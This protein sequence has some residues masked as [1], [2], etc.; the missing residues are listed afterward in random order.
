MPEG[1]GISQ[2]S[3]T[4]FAF[5]LGFTGFPE[6]RAHLR[7]ALRDGH[8]APVDPAPPSPV[9]ALVDSELRNL[10]LLRDG[11]G[12]GVRLAEAGAALAASRPL[13]VVG[14]RVSAPL[15]HLFGYLA[16][17]AHPDVRVIDAPGSPLEDGLSRAAGAPPPHRPPYWRGG[18]APPRSGPRDRLPRGSGPTCRTGSAGRPG[19]GTSCCSAPCSSSGPGPWCCRA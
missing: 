19:T 9:H 11:L 17:K 16:A 13:P 12:D 7:A 2:P 5:A 10:H 15:A 6:F 3:V 18:P 14:L 8:G 1:V 4:R